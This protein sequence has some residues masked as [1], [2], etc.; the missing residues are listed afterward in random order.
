MHLVYVHDLEVVEEPVLGGG[1]E[2]ANGHVPGG[3][4]LIQQP[5][6]AI[7]CHTPGKGEVKIRAGTTNHAGVLLTACTLNIS[8]GQKCFTTHS[9]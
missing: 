6:V 2:G 1:G 3:L 8:R 4:L 9:N 7:T 5:I